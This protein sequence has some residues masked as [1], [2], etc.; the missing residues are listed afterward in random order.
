MKLFL[1]ALAIAA[2]LTIAASAFASPERTSCTAGMTKVGG[3][4]AR[5]F[6]GPAKATVH[7]G[8]TTVQFKGG[9]CE[10][11]SAGWSINIGTVM[12]GVTSKAKPE[13]FGVAGKGKTGKQSNAAVTLTHV[14]KSYA[15]TNNTVTL[16]PGLKA[17]M[18]SGTVF[19]QSSPITGS[20]T[21]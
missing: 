7:I 3:T 4:P 12:L 10:T 20:F 16:K 15:V 8:G 1:V 13:Y 21:C 14:G 11:T 2:T 6:C 18:F 9:T 19:G 5:T 17:G